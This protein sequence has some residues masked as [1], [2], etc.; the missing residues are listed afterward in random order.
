MRGAGERFR[1]FLPHAHYRQ[2]ARAKFRNKNRLRKRAKIEN[3]TP[4]PS[5]DPY[6]PSTAFAASAI[7]AQSSEPLSSAPFISFPSFAT[8]LS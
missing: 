5:I 4:Y 2:S 6:S 8:S 1:A 3:P 7:S